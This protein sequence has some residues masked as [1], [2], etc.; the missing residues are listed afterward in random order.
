MKFELIEQDQYGGT[1]I[2]ARSEKIDELVK[3]AKDSVNDTNVDNA[4]TRQEKMNNWEAYFV[5]IEDKNTAFYSGKQSNISQMSI[6]KSSG[7]LEKKP[8]ANQSVRLYLG[9][10]DNKPWYATDRKNQP[11]KSLSED[12]LRD[13]TCYYIKSIN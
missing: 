13:K 4:L 2:I 8:L 6:I 7:V 3:K 10:L 9:E 11:V 1:T 5:E 12:F